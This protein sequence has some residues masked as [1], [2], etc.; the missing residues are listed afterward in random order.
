ML[1][2]NSFHLPNRECLM[3]CC[4]YVFQILLSTSTSSLQSSNTLRPP[5]WRIIP[6]LGPKWFIT[7]VIFFVPI[8]RVVPLPNGRTSWLTLQ[9]T[10]ISPKKKA[11]LK[12]KKSFSLSVGYVNSLEGICGGDPPTTCE[13]ILG[14]I[15][16]KL[17]S[18]PPVR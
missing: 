12:M 5:T 18:P 7:M 8:R 10:N 3:I 4:I 15:H 13:K 11:W 17:C 6:G 2:F 14:W 1:L 16:P 9:G